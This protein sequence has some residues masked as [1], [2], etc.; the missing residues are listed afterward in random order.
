MR[1]ARAVALVPL[2]LSAGA[3]R[4]RAPA[5]PPL[6]PVAYTETSA[7]FRQRRAAAIAAPDRGAAAG[8]GLA[9]QRSCW[10]ETAW[11]LAAR[12]VP[13]PTTG[14]MNI[15]DVL[16]LQTRMSWPGELRFR[17][18]GREYALQVIR[19]PED[20]DKNLFVMF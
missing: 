4:T 17:V 5:L 14:S 10:T 20:H 7:R 2:V 3:C 11:R 15:V 16:G 1:L 9:G 6:D 13:R 19:E 8:G 18:H 12:F